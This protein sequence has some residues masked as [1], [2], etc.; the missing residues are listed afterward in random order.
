MAKEK[1]NRYGWY[2]VLALSAWPFIQAGI[3]FLCAGRLDI[4]QGWLYFAVCLCNLPTGIVLLAWANPDL[5]NQRGQWRKKKDTPLWDKI[6]VRLFGVTGYYLPVITAGL[7]HGRIHGFRLP[8]YAV[9]L[10]VVLYTAGNVLFHWAMLV[11]RHFESTVRLQTDRQH[12]VVTAGPYQYVRHPGYVGA[13]TG[14]LAVPLM[15]GSAIGL[16]PSAAGCL[17]LIGRTWLEDR[18]LVKK[19]DGYAEYAAR[20]RYRLLYGVW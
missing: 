11:N 20:V 14:L 4:W 8:I 18:M 6:F 9:A 10:G 3:F 2:L 13:L 7:D 12:R 15:L 19:L 17:L 5:V 16:I 1:L